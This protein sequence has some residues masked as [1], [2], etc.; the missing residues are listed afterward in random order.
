MIDRKKQKIIITVCIFF[1]C[2]NASYF[3]NGCGNK[4]KAASPST[5][6]E[7]MDLIMESIKNLDM[8]VFNQYTDNYVE[9]YYN[10][11]GGVDVEY[12]AFNTLL[13]YRSK[14]GKRYQSEYN[15]SKKIT[16][17]LT[18]EIK[19]V[20]E[21][22][23][24]AEIDLFITNADIGK[25]LGNYEMK[26]MEDVLTGEGAGLGSLI[27]DMSELI[28]DKET[29]ISMID[30][31]GT[32][33]IVSFDVTVLAYQ[34]DDQWKIHLSPTFINAFSGNLYDADYS[35]DTKQRLSEIEEQLDDKLDNWAK[36]FENQIEN[37]FKSWSEP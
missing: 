2:L 16:E 22:S 7:T 37:R 13:K 14:Q 30:D 24:T 20:R 27:T 6:Q 8:K 34:E 36:Q 35:E 25:A 17:N 28:T 12:R 33:D 29:L 21:N 18:W 31:L 3:L 32:E 5:P 11:F 10:L 1:L 23:N 26:I 4:A 19:D 9:T 15:L